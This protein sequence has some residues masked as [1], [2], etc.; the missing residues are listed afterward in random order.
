MEQN[1]PNLS[2]TEQEIMEVLWESGEA[3]TPSQLLLHFAPL[4]D[5]KRQTMSTFLSR[6]TEKGLIS[7]KRQGREL[8]YSPILSKNQYE[9]KRSRSIINSLYQGSVTNFLASLVTEIP[10][11]PQEIEE[12]KRWLEELQDPTQGGD[13]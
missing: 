5:W 4:H 10:E 11:N 13:T 12:I 9:S 1:T 8:Y 3:K 6:L 2:Q 7:A